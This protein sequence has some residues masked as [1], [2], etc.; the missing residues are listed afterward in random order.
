MQYTKG[1]YI[2]YN[3]HNRIIMY[4]IYRIIYIVYN[5]HSFRQNPTKFYKMRQN[6]VEYCRTYKIEA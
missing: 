2:V 6:N 3:E 1:I 5:V 4:A